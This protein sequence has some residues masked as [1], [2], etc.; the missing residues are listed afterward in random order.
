MITLVLP[1]SFS[2]DDIFPH[3]W[4][5]SCCRAAYRIKRA[6][7]G[8]RESSSLLLYLNFYHN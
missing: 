3:P 4:T 1:V 5:A 7:S 8:S 2:D 6:D